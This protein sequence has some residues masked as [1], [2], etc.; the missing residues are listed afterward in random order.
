MGAKVTALA[1]DFPDG[2]ILPDFTCSVS[3]VTDKGKRLTSIQ[4]GSRSWHEN[5]GCELSM[6]AAELVSKLKEEMDVIVTQHLNMHQNVLEA[7]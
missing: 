1:F 4:V 5:G 2:Q 6:K 7:K 3:L